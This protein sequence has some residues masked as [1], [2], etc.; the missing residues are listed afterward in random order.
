MG[1]HLITKIL[2]VV[3]AVLMVIS[4]VACQVSP[5]RET[6]TSASSSTKSSEVVTTEATT[7]KNTVTE[8][9]TSDKETTTAPDTTTERVTTTTSGTVT[10]TTSK[11]EETTSKETTSSTDPVEYLDGYDPMSVRV[12]SYVTLEYNPMYCAVATEFKKGLGSSESVTL[13][14][15]M[16]D[17]YIFDGWSSGDYICNGKTATLLSSELTY[18][19][20]TNQEMNVYANYSMKV[21]YNA[22]G[23]KTKDGKDSLDTTFSLS[24]YKCPS[25][26]SDQGYFS[27]EGYV[28]S[29]YNTKADGTGTAVSLGSKIKS[30]SSTL[31]LYC[32]WLK[33][34]D[35][36]DFRYTKSTTVKITG[37]KG[38]SKDVVI[39]EKIDGLSVTA[40]ASGA[41]DGASIE[42]VFIPKTV[43]NVESN[44]F[45]NC[46]F[47]TTLVFFDNINFD[48]K[49]GDPVSNCLNFKYVRINAYYD[50]YYVAWIGETY[51][52]TDR[53]VWAQDMKKFIIYGGSGTINGID[54][55][56]INNTIGGDY[57]V[58]NMGANANVTASLVFE[59][60]SKWLN[61]GDIILWDPEPGQWTLGTAQITTRAVEF[62][63]C[64]NY[65][66]VKGVDIS[67]YQN[68]FSSLSSI[69]ASH[70]S[71]QVSWEWSHIEIDC[72][73][74][75]MKVREHQDKEYRYNFN[76]FK[77][78]D[79]THMSEV[80]D[81]L[82]ERG[83]DVWFTY[84]VMNEAAQGLDKNIVDQYIKNINDT[85]N[86][87][88]IS[89][90]Y[91]CFIGDEYYWDSEWHLINEGAT[92]R[93]TRLMNDIIAQF[94][95][96]GIN[97]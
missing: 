3:F 57:V 88:V 33:T 35:A 31:T 96:I 81:G 71:K 60:M 18:T 90:F 63:L 24:E 38:S 42:T 32:I 34:N 9:T 44:A 25:T 58:I 69:N 51:T 77:G 29:E 1:K 30:D 46:L 5:E 64:G 21:V 15:T 16:R 43:Q 83:I 84:A 97:Y 66:F 45:T 49:S 56:V 73:G 65:D 68:F 13:K 4:T 19:F 67:K 10:E 6:D 78:Y 91:D 62:V 92:I 76:Y 70:K 61:E 80:I 94:A 22:N 89:N 93:T 37:Y 2:A 8:Q 55:K 87:T 52:K 50:M 11:T 26:L 86:V 20:S 17:G 36:S 23:G 75:N 48:T 7:T 79:Y 53:L 85:F 82:K 40:I 27:R 14:I 59:G 47:L 41:F 12:G 95:K 72:F 39:P 74:D 54:S 28:L